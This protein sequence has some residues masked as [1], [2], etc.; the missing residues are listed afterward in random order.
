MNHKIEIQGREPKRKSSTRGRR[1]IYPFPTLAA[2][3]G[4]IHPKFN[5]ARVL[6]YQWH[7]KLGHRYDII[8]IG[9]G[10]MVRRVA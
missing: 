7:K 2:G 10:A 6:A 3:E 1:N 8:Q 9:R 4:F 5:T